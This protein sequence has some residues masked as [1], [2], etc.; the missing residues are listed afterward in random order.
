[1]GTLD[2]N[3]ETTV[4]TD[5]EGTVI[6]FLRITAHG[7]ISYVNPIVVDP[8]W[9]GQGVGTALMQRVADRYG[10]V[11]FVARGA[12]RRFYEKLGC[13][14]IPWSMIAPEITSDCKGCDK[15][16]TCAPCPMRLCKGQKPALPTA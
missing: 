16:E 13:E 11:R 10:E 8:P 2:P 15:A 4:A 9:H 3:P 7:G 1:M 6:G 12:S 14:D 5:A